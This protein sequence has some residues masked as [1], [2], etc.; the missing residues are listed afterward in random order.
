MTR[1]PD[2]VLSAAAVGGRG[3]ADEVPGRL[4]EEELAHGRDRVGALGPYPVV[5]VVGARVA[6]VGGQDA[7]TLGIC[8]DGAALGLPRSQA[9]GNVASGGARAAVAV[10][11]ALSAFEP[12]PEAAPSAGRAGFGGRHPGR[13]Q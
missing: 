3:R 13:V 4:G 6:A 1:C 11:P 7:G 2:H 10:V 9:A 12:W 8:V 5:R